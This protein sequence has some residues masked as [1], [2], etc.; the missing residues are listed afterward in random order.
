MIGFDEEK[1]KKK[2]ISYIIG[3]YSFVSFIQKLLDGSEALVLPV[4]SKLTIGQ[5]DNNFRSFLG[6]SGFSGGIH[7]P[8]NN[9][10][11]A[12]INLHQ[13]SP[14]H[15]VTEATTAIGGSSDNVLSTV[16][17]DNSFSVLA[18]VLGLGIDVSAAFD[19]SLVSGA[20]TFGVHAESSGAFELSLTSHT[21]QILA[22]IHGAREISQR[23]G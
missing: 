8:S 5:R 10:L 4:R 15:N 3:L 17:P 11:P 18:A 7:V 22:A 16:G 20:V 19:T 6:L 21:L 14:R 2:K 13:S 1:R 9:V 23:K 12:Q